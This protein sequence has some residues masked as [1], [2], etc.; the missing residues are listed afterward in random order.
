L[1]LDGLG[2]FPTYF[3]R[4]PGINQ[5]GV[6]HYDQ[7]PALAALNVDAVAKAV[8]DGAVVVDV[9]PITEYA[10]SHVPSSLSIELR[11]V[12]ASWLGWTVEPAANLVFVINPDQN[13][14]DLVRQCLTIGFERFAG[15]LDGGIDAWTKSGRL[16]SSV[17]IVDAG[18]RRGTTLDIR[19]DSEYADGHV[20]GAMHVELGALADADLPD[21]P[22]TTMCG[23]HE[24]A[25]TGASILERRGRTDLAVLYDG[26]GGWRDGGH[27][28]EVG[29]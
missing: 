20:P 26:F 15:Y 3:S 14:D 23:H 22:I 29:E 19:Q 13:T 27:P 4:L 2:T 1:L 28:V 24:R 5:H 10:E 11:G 6:T 12:F 17:D 25:M 9:R 18:T 16:T 7:I 21:G 8:A